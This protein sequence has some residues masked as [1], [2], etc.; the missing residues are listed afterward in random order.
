MYIFFKPPFQHVVLGLIRSLAMMAV[1]VTPGKIFVTEFHNVQIP[2]M[3][4]QINHV[5][6]IPP[7]LLIQVT[8]CVCAIKDFWY[9]SRALTKIVAL[10]TLIILA[11]ISGS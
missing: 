10:L 7:H 1:V 4:P 8:I 5:L 11:V 3:N 2:P 9:V 6:Q